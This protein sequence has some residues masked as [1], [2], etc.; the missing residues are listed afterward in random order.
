MATHSHR[1]RILLTGASGHLGAVLRQ[2]LDDSPRYQLVLVD[3]VSRGER[4][5]LEADLS[6]YDGRW[7][8]L[9]SDV[10]TVIHFAGDPGHIRTSPARLMAQN[11]G[12][13]LNVFRAARKCEVRRVIYAS[14]LQILEGYR[15]GRGLIAGGAPPRIVSAYAATKFAGETVARYFAQDHGISAICLRIGSVPR[16]P[17]VPSR[18]W[19]AWR[20]SKWLGTDDLCQAVELAIL[21]DDLR[22]A[23]VPLVSDNTAMRWD[24]SETRRLL[25][26]FPRE[27]APSPSYGLAINIRS[28]LRMLHRRFFDP[29][30]RRYWD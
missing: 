8:E 29:D 27:H 10:H 2:Y 26:Y 9:F 11:M 25:G 17:L 6:E 19:S 30:W 23:V 5:I 28:T 18:S 1:L 4:D 21:A 3:K 15:Y 13:T 22:L 24:L 7:A 20:L 12:A 16:D 14:T